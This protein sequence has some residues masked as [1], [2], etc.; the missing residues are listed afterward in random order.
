MDEKLKA[1]I[2]DYGGAELLGSRLGYKGGRQTINKQLHKKNPTLNTLNRVA[3]QMGMHGKDFI[4][5]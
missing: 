2:L 1:A 5:A 3:E 4:K